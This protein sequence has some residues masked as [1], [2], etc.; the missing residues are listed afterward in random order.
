MRKLTA[1][2][3][4]II[5]AGAVLLPRQGAS[6]EETMA[7]TAQE[8]GFFKSA[9]RK[10]LDTKAA[11]DEKLPFEIHGFMEGAMGFLPDKNKLIRNHS[12]NLLQGRLQ[13]KGTYYPEKPELL[14]DWNT[15]FT[16]KIDFVGDGISEDFYVDFRELNVQFSPLDFMDVKVGRQI[17][18]WG[19]GDLIFI[20]D[21]FPKDWVAFFTGL[22]DEYLKAPSDAM[23]VSLFSEI[24][25]LDFVLIPYMQP[26][27]YFK[28]GERLSFYDPIS[29]RIVGY[30]DHVH[31]DRPARDLEH[32]EFAGRLYRNFGSYEAAIYGF[33]GYYNR[34]LGVKNPLTDEY[35]YPRLNEI[36]ASL[37]GPV[38][39]IGGIG[40]IEAGFYDS[41]QD[42][43]GD[44][45][46]IENSSMKYL[47][48][49][50]RELWRDL[51][52]GLQYYAE[53]MLQYGR[54][55]HTRPPGSPA[56][57]ELR[58]MVTLRLT[59]LLFSQNVELSLFTFY[60]P[61]D[62]DFHLRP[63][64]SWDITDH[65]TWTLGSDVFAG[66]NEFTQFGMLRDDNNIY[67]RL[68]FNF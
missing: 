5:I 29:G 68:R 54:Y 38:P 21:L 47:I 30:H 14:A 63:R 11:L 45:P 4:S 51:T 32:M 64:I 18:T 3:L 24:A 62:E 7:E 10:I 36:G 19:T 40:N 6:Q 1:Y 16:F 27:N 13:L 57:D 33:H 58:Q 25:N 34:P 60:S 61:T 67:T 17:L 50:E 39:K 28:E 31:Y 49:Y 56:R 22:D 65:W 26:D 2:S 23:K 48:G 8:D 46:F 35:F 66:A 59:Q 20:N 12:F 43:K 53:Q 42:I 55:N 41:Q 37:R 44:D 9:Y 52:V 15:V